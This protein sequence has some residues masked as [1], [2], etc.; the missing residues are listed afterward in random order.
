MAADHDK[1]SRKK[2]IFFILFSLLTITIMISI[3]IIA[4]RKNYGLE[5]DEVFSYIS[6]TS[7]GGFKQICFLKDQM[8]YDADYF[9]N[10][11]TATGEER[12][13]IKMVFENQAM[14][15]HPPLY[16]LFL[17][18][19]CSLFPGQFSVW[20]G[21]GLNILFM[22]LAGFG[23]YLLLQH[24]LASRFMSMF[25]TL[26]FCC[27]MLAVD[28][29]L[30]IRMYV[31]LMALTIFQS[32]YH[33]DFYGRVIESVNGY[34]VK[35][36]LKRYLALMLITILGA[37]THYYFLVYQCLIAAVYMFGLWLRKRYQDIFRYIGTMAASGFLYVCLYPAMLNHIFFKYRGR[38]A[39]H[40]F[41]NEDTLFG[42]VISMF[43]IFNN[44]LFKGWL[45]FLIL[46]STLISVFLL[47]KKK[48]NWRPLGKGLILTLP[49]LVYFF[50]ISKASPYVAI[51]YVSPIAP[52]L[53]TALAVWMKYLIDHIRSSTVWQRKGHIALCALLALSTVYLFQ[54][55]LKNMSFSEKKTVV[56]SLAGESEYCI[57]ITA[58]D[59]NW[60]MWEDYIHYPQFQSLFFVDGRYQKAITDER[61]EGLD[62]LTIFIDKELDLDE[63]YSYLSKYLSVTDFDV[64]YETSYIYIILAT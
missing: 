53:F 35:Q 38:E 5:G 45:P 32:W 20:I 26:V 11:L 9:S 42:N 6:S 29:V 57:Y 15:T 54:T 13:N 39:M 4:G 58:D 22:I 52:L 3:Y 17:N 37:L 31:L 49:S 24:F 18:L 7:M 36:H 33:L 55:P 1:G 62:K 34:P 51:R 19:A 48:I 30:F 47:F 25:L 61:L 10:A 8:W 16:Y 63:M 60:K 56:D 59:Y 44:E 12:F 23:L 41:L 2:D 50:G 21:I 46:I 28:M 43:S 40:K 14:D 27:S 64:K